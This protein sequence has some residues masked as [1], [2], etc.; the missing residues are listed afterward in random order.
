M[1]KGRTNDTQHRSK[2]I[3]IIYLN[4]MCRKTEICVY[5]EKELLPYRI[6]TKMQRKWMW[7][8]CSRWTFFFFL[9]L[10]PNVDSKVTSDEIRNM[11]FLSF[12]SNEKIYRSCLSDSFP[13]LDELC[14]IE[15]L[16]HFVSSREIDF[17]NYFNFS[18]T[19]IERFYF[20]HK[21]NS[22]LRTVLARSRLICDPFQI[23][24]FKNFVK[25]ALWERLSKVRVRS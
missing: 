14:R 16:V 21:I 17:C 9:F 10:W 19:K 25:N 3:F 8:I 24:N 11:C 5:V 18:K 13:L 4:F 1:K 22:G 23:E 15:I 12:G 7:K 6:R 2:S 20:V